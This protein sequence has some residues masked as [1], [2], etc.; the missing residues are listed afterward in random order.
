[1]EEHTSYAHGEDSRPIFEC[2]T[3]KIEFTD[4]NSLEN[5]VNLVHAIEK[6]CKFCGK[7]Y[8]H[9]DRLKAHLTRYGN[10]AYRVFRLDLQN[11]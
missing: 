8:T 5:H 4:E 9:A 1:M 7:I 3:C 6:K 11:T 10:L 2:P